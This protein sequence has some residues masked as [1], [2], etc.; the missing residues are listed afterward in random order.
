[1]AYQSAYNMNYQIL[2]CLILFSLV[3]LLPLPSHSADPSPLQD[4]CVAD[5]DSSL[6]INGF[7]CKNPDNV[8]SQ[9]FFANGF[10][11]SPGEFNIF[12][13]NVTRQ[14]V[15]RFP[16]LNTLGLSMNRVVLKPGGLNAPHVHPRAAE[17]ALVMDGKLFVGFVTTGNVFYW[18]IVTSG[19]LFVIPPGL[20]HFQ[21][22]IGH[23]NAR[24]FASFNSQNPGIQFAPLA[25]FNSTPSIPDLVLSKA[26]QVNQSIIELI[27]S[28]FATVSTVSTVLKS[29]Y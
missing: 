25:L 20:V 1:M 3:L 2:L 28:R 21:L 8:S 10:Q 12:D 24:F 7:P 18:K 5:L 19:E 16:G 23:E 15:Q 13:V 14:D 29:S 17:L 27:K 22:N 6:Y 26:F 9:D 11:Q 4:F